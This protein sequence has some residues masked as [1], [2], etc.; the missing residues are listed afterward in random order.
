[1]K[2]VLNAKIRFLR[3]TVALCG[4][5]LLFFV[6]T[7]SKTWAFEID[8]TGFS[9]PQR[10]TS[11]MYYWHEGV[12]PQAVEA[13]GLGPGYY[14]LIVWGSQLY[15]KDNDTFFTYLTNQ[16]IK[17]YQDFHEQSAL[18]TGTV[19][20]IKYRNGDYPYLNFGS[21]PDGYPHGEY[22][23]QAKFPATIDNLVENA[24]VDYEVLKAVGTAVSF[25]AK[26][27]MPKLYSLSNSE[28]NYAISFLNFDEGRDFH[29]SFLGGSYRFISTIIKT[30][31][32]I[33]TVDTI[34]SNR[35]YWTLQYYTFR[36]ADWQANLASVKDCFLGNEE[37]AM[38][39]WQFQNAY[40]NHYRI[41]TV[42]TASS[43]VPRIHK[44]DAWSLNPFE[45]QFKDYKDVEKM[46]D[47]KTA[48]ISFKVDGSTLY[49]QGNSTVGDGYEFEIF[50]A[51]PQIVSYLTSDFEVV[52]GQS[53]N[54]DGPIIIPEGR[55]ITVKNG[56]VLSLKGWIIN[57]GTIKVEEGGTLLVQEDT[58]VSTTEE[59]AGKTNGRIACD[60]VMIVAP[61]AK[62][63]CGGVDGLKFG[64]GAQCVNYGALIAENLTVYTD[65]TIEN[66]G[67][68]SCVFAGWGIQ[69][70]GFST[71][72]LTIYGSTFTTM[73]T[74]EKSRSISIPNLGV[75]GEGASRV[76]VNPDATYKTPGNQKGSACASLGP[77]S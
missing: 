77:S 14:V 9:K 58:M 28:S 69:D 55:T 76:Y 36:E 49:S 63:Q 62:V 19:N 64:E 48:D 46:R 47:R 8:T 72:Q 35:A 32:E 59:K 3:R 50:Y 41:F 25:D 53:S 68:S 27:N 37:K 30:D 15:W 11:M 52:N 34:E 31:I 57:N 21:Y 2:K 51:E 74:R 73:S 60:G 40:S 13:N 22:W 26:L 71:W 61:G 17:D 5:L 38:F 66:R 65:H 6:L 39:T 44:Y 1:M 75:Y 7:S 29:E 54:L 24:P 43:K 70:T 45:A 33:T 4:I 23:Y 67:S 16:A 18:S 12:P 56:G 42:G 10:E 20:Q